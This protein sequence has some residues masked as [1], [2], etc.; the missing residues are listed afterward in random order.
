[1]RKKLFRKVTTSVITFLLITSTITVQAAELS[2]GSK[3]IEVIK[4]QNALKNL[5]YFKYDTATGY[6]GD[7]TSESVINYQS[8][9]GLEKTGIINNETFDKI[10]SE[11]KTSEV[12]QQYNGALD[13]FKEVQNIFYRGCDAIVTDVATGKSFNVKRTFGTN[14]ADIEP[15]TIQDSETIKSIWGGW[16]WERRAVTVKVGDYYL[17]G[18]MTA[19]PHA[20][21]DSKPAVKVVSGRSGGYGTGQNLDAV[22]GNGIDGHMDIHFLNSRTHGT[23]VV[24]KV[25]Q[26]MVKKSSQYILNNYNK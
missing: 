18:S 26:D 10:L 2:K 22:K 9:K 3:G 21:L 24:Q 17:A 19:F 16:S 5:G 11:A 23:N 4:L 7:I 14:H 25:H 8:S 6:Y 15:L 12:P 13:W 1:M 20:G